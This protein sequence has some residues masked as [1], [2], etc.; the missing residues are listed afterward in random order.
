MKL[1]EVKEIEKKIP[2]H[3]HIIEVVYRAKR[4]IVEA[5]PCYLRVLFDL[6]LDQV[7]TPMRDYVKKRHTE[8]PY[9][10]VATHF[11]GRGAPQGLTEISVKNLDGIRILDHVREGYPLSD[12]IEISY[13][14]KIG[15][16]GLRAGY[17]VNGDELVSRF[18]DDD[19]LDYVELY[20]SRG[21]NRLNGPL[22]IENVKNLRRLV[23][24]ESGGF[25]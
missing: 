9:L 17:S 25:S 16:Y 21:G 13:E 12:V 7:P 23:I 5:M 8:P 15:P 20:P 11:D 14:E 10:K 6:Y 24:V 18:R 22:K 19:K 3:S 4:G 2:T 1:D